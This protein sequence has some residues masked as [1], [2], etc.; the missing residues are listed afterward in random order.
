MTSAASS[1]TL[2]GTPSPP[3]SPSRDPLQAV[4][5]R[6]LENLETSSAAAAAV[7][8]IE[9]HNVGSIHVANDSAQPAAPAPPTHGSV[10]QEAGQEGARAIAAHV[11]DL[12][13]NILPFSQWMHEQGLR[14]TQTSGQGL[15]CYINALLQHATRDYTQ[16]KFPQTEELR[17]ALKEQFPQV[18]GT[19]HEDGPEALFLIQQVA[20]S[21]DTPL[22]VI[23]IHAT[24]EGLPFIVHR[25]A[26]EGEPVVIWNQGGHFVSVIG[27]DDPAPDS[28]LDLLTTD[29]DVLSDDLLATGDL[30]GEELQKKLLAHLFDTLKGY[31]SLQQRLLEQFPGWID[32]PARLRDVAA[33]MRGLADD[34]DR[35]AKQAQM[36]AETFMRR[37][38]LEEETERHFDLAAAL[39]ARTHALQTQAKALS[40]AQKEKQAT[41]NQDLQK[42][43]KLTTQSLVYMVL[44]VDTFQEQNDALFAHFFQMREAQPDKFDPFLPMLLS[45]SHFDKASMVRLLQEAANIN[46]SLTHAFTFYVTWTCS[47]LGFDP[48][49]VI[50]KRAPDVYA[51]LCAVYP[52]DRISRAFVIAARNHIDNFIL[53]FRPIADSFQQG[54]AELIA[55][56]PAE[57][58]KTFAACRLQMEGFAVVHRYLALALALNGEGAKAKRAFE[59][60]GR[61]MCIS[62]HGTITHPYGNNTMMPHLLRMISHEKPSKPAPTEKPIDL[63]E[64]L[65]EM[66]CSPTS[67]HE[68]A[69]KFVKGALSLQEALPEALPELFFGIRWIAMQALDIPPES[70]LSEALL[71]LMTWVAWGVDEPDEW[72]TEHIHRLQEEDNVAIQVLIDQITFG[73]QEKAQEAQLAFDPALHLTRQ[74]RSG[75][76]LSL[77]KELFRLV[78]HGHFTKLAS[79]SIAACEEAIP[80]PESAQAMTSLVQTAVRT[81]GPLLRHARGFLNLY[82]EAEPKPYPLSPTFLS[83]ARFAIDQLTVAGSLPSNLQIPLKSLLGPHVMRESASELTLAYRLAHRGAERLA[84]RR[85][86]EDETVHFPE[87]A[88]DLYT[89][90]Q[91]G[92]SLFGRRIDETLEAW[93][94]RLNFLQT[95]EIFSTGSSPPGFNFR[96][97]ES[98]TPH[99]TVALRGSKALALLKWT[100]QEQL[101]FALDLHIKNICIQTLEDW[102]GETSIWRQWCLDTDLETQTQVVR[103]N[104]APRLFP[105]QEQ[106]V[107][108][109]HVAS[110]HDKEAEVLKEVAH[111]RKI[112]DSIASHSTNIAADM[113]ALLLALAE[114]GREETSARH[115]IWV[116]TEALALQ[117]CQI[118]LEA[119]HERRLCEALIQAGPEHWTVS[120]AAMDAFKASM[121]GFSQTIHGP[122]NHFNN[123]PLY[124]HYNVFTYNS[125]GA[126]QNTH[127]YFGDR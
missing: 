49:L 117:V 10:E 26:T 71:S 4:A 116:P 40:K 76:C 106:R 125:R 5:E 74:S 11:A 85:T 21:F 37:Q 121:Q 48:F 69:L 20:E 36:Q 28:L 6:A 92:Y 73:P 80:L 78:F 77:T 7:K 93:C 105:H 12:V 95:Y 96:A 90:I 9:R 29:P 8:I 3:P 122:E 87:D 54:F 22:Q 127:I 60:A 35:E 39:K 115:S 13:R 56:S 53:P 114:R 59:R 42:L 98:S 108:E 41:W 38:T 15:N 16:P 23:T 102:V 68:S 33:A 72:Y 50:R 57:A 81:P 34:V 103:T 45:I 14:A 111:L 55:G 44:G 67:A 88:T 110:K 123:G 75:I 52:H 32:T 1:T 25:S 27:S 118:I 119:N 17:K 61:L 66:V 47:R 100:L 89:V 109:A 83:W 120:D 2:G 97:E 91:L 94:E 63:L 107:F 112:Y 19:L 86:M 82:E 46:P 70:A 18:E 124:T 65:I 62:P 104:T 99:Y 30:E 101:N 84:Q 64:L 31:P 79:S 24:E 113:A 58:V 43:Y 51:A 126:H